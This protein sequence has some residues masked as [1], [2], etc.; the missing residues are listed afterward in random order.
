MD[1]DFST[2]L[3][4]IS[5]LI[6][7]CKGMHGLNKAEYTNVLRYLYKTEMKYDAVEIGTW[8]GITTASMSMVAKH[9]NT[10]K[11]VFGIDNFV[12]PLNNPKGK[13]ALEN[14]N[15]NIDIFGVKDYCELI[16]G[17]SED[18]IFDR[19]IGFLFIDGGHSYDQVKKDIEKYVPL[20]VSG[21]YVVFHDYNITHPQICQAIDEA[22]LG[23][24]NK[25]SK[26]MYVCRR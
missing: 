4:E 1:K 3:D 24:D 13:E 5:E 18:V 7:R 17:H 25:D 10:G 9:F 22:K 26:T 6:E 11:K 8:N 16:I 21:G 23:G 19:K 15:H 20:V 2:L 14:F 12:W